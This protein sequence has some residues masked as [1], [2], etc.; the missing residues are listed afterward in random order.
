MAGDTSPASGQWTRLHQAAKDGDIDAIL[1]LLEAK[2]EV[3]ATDK[4][5]RTPLHLAAKKGHNEAIKFLVKAH[6]RV[7]TVDED[8]WTPLHFAA[9][10]GHT[11]TVL[12]LLK[13]RANLDAKT[14]DQLTPLHLAAENG[15]VDIAE[16]L[17]KADAEVD[18]RAISQKTSLHR[19]AAN[20]HTTIIKALLKADAEVDT[21]D[22]FQ[23]TPLHLAAENGHASV[24]KALL[25]ADAEIDSR[26]KS[27]W[28]PLHL[29]SSMGHNIALKALLQA[30]AD[31]NALNEAQIT[32]LHFGTT[33]GY[34][35][36]IKTLLEAG[37]EAGARDNKQQTPLHLAAK[38]GYADVL[39]ALI[40]V[41][42]AVDAQD[43]DR[44]TP[45]HLAAKNGHTI[46]IKP[47]LEA[48]AE[49]DAMDN[50]QQTA[51][52]LAA[53]SGRTIPI[54]VLINAGSEVDAQDSNQQTP[55]HLA[56]V[57]GRIMPIKI[58]LEA[59]AE[60]DAQD[61]NRWT[62]LHLAAH[63]GHTKAVQALLEAK[64]RIDVKTKD[65]LTPCNLAAEK[66]HTE[67][68]KVLLEAERNCNPADSAAAFVDSTAQEMT[69]ESE[70]SDESEENESRSSTAC[71]P[72]YTQPIKEKTER[73][74]RDLQQYQDTILQVSRERSRDRFERQERREATMNLRRE[75][76][77]YPQARLSHSTTVQDRKERVVERSHTQEWKEAERQLMKETG[78][79]P[80]K[81]QRQL[82]ARL[83][84]RRSRERI[85]DRFI[86]LMSDT[87]ALREAAWDFLIFLG[88]LPEDDDESA[89]DRAFQAPSY[90]MN[91][92]KVN[93]EETQ[94]AQS[95]EET[96]GAHLPDPE[97]PMTTAGQDAITTNQNQKTSKKDE[98]KRDHAISIEPE[99]KPHSSESGSKPVDASGTA[100]EVQSTPFMH[101]SRFQD[102]ELAEEELD[103]QEKRHISVLAY[104]DPLK[105]HLEATSYA[106][107]ELEGFGKL[108]RHWF[109]R[110]DLLA[111]WRTSKRK[112]LLPEGSQEVSKQED[113][114]KQDQSLFDT[115]RFLGHSTWLACLT[116][117]GRH[118]HEGVVTLFQVQ[119]D[120]TGETQWPLSVRPISVM[121]K[122]P[123]V[124]LAKMKAEA[125]GTKV[126]LRIKKGALGWG[127][128]TQQSLNTLRGL[129]GDAKEDLQCGAVSNPDI[130]SE[131]IGEALRTALHLPYV[132][133][134]NCVKATILQM[135][136]WLHVSASYLTGVKTGGLQTV[137]REGAMVGRV[138]KWENSPEDGK[139]YSRIVV[140]GPKD[141]WASEPVYWL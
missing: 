26:T 55:L 7:D 63:N 129:V 99:P 67:T 76:E 94:V 113:P 31:V 82:T 92:R 5:Q 130:R 22:K 13:A 2:A 122:V 134:Q 33:K 71:I 136:A 14:K 115:N 110:E 106:T 91:E 114:K 96:K 19:A 81:L 57:V 61:K 138:V 28:T 73:Y 104:Y 107:V 16:A 78:R 116:Y 18:S 86:E 132:P 40:K 21:R 53:M 98:P 17:L 59:G 117:G 93:S 20:G 127:S 15:H 87:T 29:A 8:E 137:K 121:K 124:I 128:K 69:E 12:A 46:V 79:Y 41:S 85:V 77:W 118:E 47:L 58:L 32:P 90:E 37:A 70:K 45:L 75:A 4:S 84:D 111:L 60:V 42:I 126:T 23:R 56:A 88:S 103:F 35:V 51:L 133:G 97:S 43:H 50:K 131:S 34:T 38:N 49:V 48:G 105:V 66:D 52:H 24:I 30:G 140:M 54:K 6:A 64:A 125:A 109:H 25:K 95:G 9:S 80:E 100:N 1:A 74:P 108:V 135:L 89:E 11:K 27:Q 83:Q 65:Q 36:V 139:G 72:M 119:L 123:R 62:P 141:A 10:N 44:Q 102:H 3:D 101:W 39:K 112:I 120:G 68:V